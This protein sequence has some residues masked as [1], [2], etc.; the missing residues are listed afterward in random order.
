MSAD[1][2]GFLGRWSA[3]KRRRDAARGDGPGAGSDADA[4]ANADVGVDVDANAAG[5]VDPFGT[6]VPGTAPGA[7]DAVRP[8]AVAGSSP[9]PG[10][11]AGSGG[12]ADADG[13]ARA[14]DDAPVLTDV[15]M[16]PIE[17]L[18]G[19]SD[20]SA[21]FS[22]GVSATLRRAALRRVFAQPAFNVRDG[23]NDYDGDYTVFE[24]LGDTVTADMKYHAARHERDRLERER[25]ALEEEARER[26]A[27]A[28]DAERDDAAE[29]EADTDT[30]TDTDPDVTIST[31]TDA[32]A[33]ARSSDGES[34]PD[35]PDAP[36]SPTREDGNE[37]P[38]H[39]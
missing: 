30:D 24:P 33:G 32:A 21:F 38:T 37:S 31:G 25:L 11:D 19:D 2:T 29:A 16:P 3:R 26:E 17:S 22:E 8:P 36:T 20:L 39:A 10:A 14:T 15:D 18:R 23:L 5:D 6:H 35:A 1:D 28:A 9:P 12:E 7:N 27:R 4:D 13:D 34:A